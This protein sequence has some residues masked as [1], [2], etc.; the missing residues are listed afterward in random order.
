[1]AIDYYS[2]IDLHQNELQNA[3]IQVLSTKPS[4][5]LQGQIFFDSDVTQLQVY[6]GSAWQ[7]L[8]T[9]VVDTD[10]IFNAGLRIGRDSHN[11]LDFET[12]DNTIDIYLN[13]AKDFT[14]T[15]NT[16]T[17]QSGSTIAA[18]A[19]TATTGTF[20][21]VLKTDS[22]T[23]AT[24]TTDGSLQTDGG[25]SVALDAVIGDDLVL[26]SDA[27]VLSLGA[28]KDVTITHDNGTGG[29]L[30]SAGNFVVDSTAGTMTID[31][32]NALTLQSA[33]DIAI[34]A[35]GNDI[36]M[37]TDHVVIESTATA[38]PTL[39][40]KSTTNSNVGSS[41][42]FISD[43]GAAGADND[44]IG[45]IKF[46]GDDTA[47][48]Q[49]QFARIVGSVS[50][51]AN[52]DE[53]G[54]LEF[55]VAESNG[56][57]TNSN[58]VGLLI[59]GEH[60][61]DGQIDVTIAAGAASTTTVAGTLTMGSTATINN[62][63][64]WV[65]GVIPSAKLDEDT[66]HL[67]TAQSFSGA[68]TF[69]AHTVQASNT[70]LRFRDSAI[71]ISSSA[72]G[73]LDL[74]ADTEIQIAA[75]TID[76]NGAVVASGEIEAASLDINGNA[77]ISGDLT[78][79]DNVTSTNYVVGGHTVND[80]DIGT[81][82]VDADDHIMSSG[83]IVAKFGLIAGSSSIVTTGVLNSGSINTSFGNINN[84]ASTITTTGLISGGSLDIDDV[85]I[86]GTNIGHTD[87]TDLIALADGA[88]TVNGSLTV[89]GTT[90]TNNVETV[91]TSSGVV[92]EGAAADGHDATLKSVVAS[93]D[94]TYTL[95]NTTGFIGI[96]TTDP[97]TT[98]VTATTA[99]L[100][101]LDLGST[102]VGNAI[103]SKAV[104]LDS[105]KDFAGLNTITSTNYVVGGHTIDDIDITAEFVDADAHI[106]SSKAIGAR[107][108]LKNADTTGLAGTAT[109][110]ATTRAFQTDLASTSAVNFNGTAANT[111]GVTGTLAVG[112]GGTGAAN[113]N[114]LVQLAGSQ[115]LTGTKTLNSFKGTGGA[116][117]TNIL[118]EDAMGSDSATALATQQSIK[119]YVDANAAANR[120]VVLVLNN[121]VSGVASSDNVTYKVTHSLNTRNVMVEVIR[122]GANSGDYRTVYVDVHRS[123]DDVVDIVFGSARTAGDYTVMIQK[124]G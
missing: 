107:F 51:S 67:T 30:A 19:L 10:D 98:N 66:A 69:E 80:I 5:P 11:M 88:V 72:D 84:G 39:T 32:H 54:K 76:I 79:L 18:Q 23:N 8:A 83:A 7:G 13:N 35:G 81:E 2:S 15:A 45:S 53:A 31:G 41:L 112:N 42:E 118:D 73:Q 12:A 60:A 25:L 74:V 89:T 59:E 20:S 29:T 93:S 47:Q 86:N 34:V 26:I 78:G 68:K 109:A 48:V 117:V 115:T 116:T 36:T 43:K 33:N 106:M 71:H 62:S 104:V 21:G 77:D 99:E 38:D 49:T 90:T 97:G 22:T 65:G 94:K 87:D 9:E 123:T 24:S 114:H 102:A 101:A 100:N 85:V 27:A 14:F 75:T 46:I 121:S 103:A 124:I 82:F 119:A 95:P 70:Q 122:N 58:T 56:T 113:L 91:S 63:G 52:S 120:E 40:L 28:G 111:H 96:F 16:F 105:S 108:A 61:T 64:V 44:V 4:S 50:E 110:L 17:A 6:N 92:F 3:V 37:D 57:A 1:M 55:F